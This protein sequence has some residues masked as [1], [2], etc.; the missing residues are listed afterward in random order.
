MKQQC[1]VQNKDLFEDNDV[2]A[3]EEEL[4][5]LKMQLS[6]SVSFRN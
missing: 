1:E 2:D 5:Q 3:L 4:E 6:E